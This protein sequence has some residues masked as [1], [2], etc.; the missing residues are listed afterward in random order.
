MRNRERFI[1]AEATLVD[2]EDTD[3]AIYIYA[4]AGRLAAIGYH[5]KANKPD[6]H[7]TFRTEAARDSHVAG[8]IDGRRLRAK[9]MT[10]RKVNRNGAHNWKVGQIIYC[11]WGYDQTNIDFFEV[12]EVVGQHTVKIR[13]LCQTVESATPGSDRVAAAPGKYLEGERGEVMTKRVNGEADQGAVK[14]HS[15]G[16]YARP[17]DGT[18]R[19]QTAAGYGH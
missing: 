6:F 14:I 11:S 19:Y 18:P 3:A 17:W 7:H 16:V 9:R 12:V 5:G 1:P 8:F 4:K 10:E 2:A 13:A 15:W